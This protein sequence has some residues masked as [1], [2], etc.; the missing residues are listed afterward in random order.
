M[1][2]GEKSTLC[3]FCELPATTRIFDQRG[4]NVDTCDEH[5]AKAINAQLVA[6]HV[7]SLT[8]GK[9]IPILVEWLIGAESD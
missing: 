8:N 2:D 9:R 7:R 3:S 5:M 6:P 1:T 4:G